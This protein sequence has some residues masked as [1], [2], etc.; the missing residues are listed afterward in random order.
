MG[1]P[2]HRLIGHA[3]RM[4]VLLWV[5]LSA[6]V[7]VAAPPPMPELPLPEH[8]MRQVT[9]AWHDGNDTMFVTTYREVHRLVAGGEVETWSSEI[10]VAVDGDGQGRGARAVFAV[11]DRDGKVARFVS[12]TWRTIDLPL[13]EG[14]KVVAVSISAKGEVFIVGSN[15]AVYVWD[16]EEI[17]VE[18]YPEG[19]RVRALA[20][21]STPGGQLFIV[22]ADALLLRFDNR[23]FRRIVVA[24]LRE[25]VAFAPWRALWYSSDSGRVWIRAGQDGLLAIDPDTAEA[26]DHRI[27]TVDAEARKGDFASV[28]GVTTVGGDQL[29]LS[30]G[31]SVYRFEDGRFRF[32]GTESATVYELGFSRLEDAVYVAT[33]DG[34]KRRTLGG[35]R[36]VR[37]LRPLTASEARMLEETERRERRIALTPKSQLLQVPTVRVAF[38]TALQGA[39]K[40]RR[41]SFALDAGVGVLLTPLQN[42]QGPTVWVWPEVAYHLDTHPA[43]GYHVGSIGSGI[44]FGTHLVSGHYVPRF[45]AGASNAGGRLIGFRHGVIVQALWGVAGIELSQQLSGTERGFEQDFRLMFSI[46]LAPVV[47]VL[48]LATTL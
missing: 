21:R 47:W 39:L 12:G 31:R 41:V 32:V 14:D 19:Y 11:A 37:P 7:A 26:V 16:D 33:Q 15:K 24:G 25:S 45:V 10:D 44:G 28:T 27:P 38:G 22:G 20:G 5:W 1:E 4:A 18:P 29:V 6:S 35:E 46:N 34:L 9:A 43:R 8:G 2:H 23:G 17:E 30:M 13:L 3:L 42:V 48:I 40:T 36:Q